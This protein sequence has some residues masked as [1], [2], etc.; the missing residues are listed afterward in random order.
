M[1]KR[2]QKFGKLSCM[3]CCSKLTYGRAVIKSR[4]LGIS[5]GYYECGPRLLS[6]ENRRK[7]EPKEIPSCFILCL[8]VVFTQQPEILVTYLIWSDLNCH[9]MLN[10]QH[11][12]YNVL[13]FNILVERFW[14]LEIFPE[15]CWEFKN[16]PCTC[17]KKSV[18]VTQHSQL[19]ALWKEMFQNCLWLCLI[20]YESMII[21]TVIKNLAFDYTD[22]EVWLKS[23]TVILM[24]SYL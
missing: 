16:P 8:L 11:L 2:D 3:T 21:I 10:F 1:V 23:R 5:P 19:T 6:L 12:V 7:I 9:K 13:N 14:K 17:F 18:W 20:I 4:G 24:S 22:Q 15:R